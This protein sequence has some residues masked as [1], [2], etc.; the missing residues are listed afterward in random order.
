[1]QFRLDARLAQRGMVVSLSFLR[2][3]TLVLKGRQPRV[4]FVAGLHTLDELSDNKV[5]LKKIKLCIKAFAREHREHVD[6]ICDALRQV[7]WGS[8]L[9]RE[10]AQ[11]LS[12]DDD[13]DDV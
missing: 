10:I 6:G 5:A 11:P 8:V 9:A 12:D 2:F 7:S 3:L 13:D 4:S 1:M